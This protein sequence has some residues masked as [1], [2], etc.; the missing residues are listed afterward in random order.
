MDRDLLRSASV[1]DRPIKDERDAFRTTRAQAAIVRTLAA[2]TQRKGQG[3]SE[4]Q[5]LRVQVVEES[6][7]LVWAAA[8]LSKARSTAPPPAHEE[9]RPE[10]RSP[11]DRPW[12]RILVVEDDDSTRD[13]IVRGLAPEYEVVAAAN[14]VEGLKAASEL[15][16]DAIVSDMWMPEMDGITMV[17]EI[18]RTQ[19]PAVIPVIFLTAETAPE[20]IADG[21]AAGATTYLVKPIDLGL[22][23]QELRLALA[24]SSK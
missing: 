15:R 12:P 5:A 6:A 18:M 24:G 7:R 14:G 1:G 2:E 21:F 19:A 22:L 17:D 20:R 23:D 9:T 4:T 16:F 3:D 13:A 11:G 10:G 8:D